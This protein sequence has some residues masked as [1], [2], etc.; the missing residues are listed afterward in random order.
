MLCCSLKR[1]IKKHRP[2]AHQY[3]YGCR[4]LPYTKSTGRPR[5][6]TKDLML[7]TN[8]ELLTINSGDLYA[9]GVA[10]TRLDAR[11]KP[12]QLENGR[13]DG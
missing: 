7:T 4:A 11:A 8:A 13:D 5:T 6:H 3:A 12:K 10:E 9:L 1:N 2:F